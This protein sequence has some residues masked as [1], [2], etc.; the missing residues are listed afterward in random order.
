MPEHVCPLD[1]ERHRDQVEQAAKKVYA[2]EVIKKLPQAY[3][4]ELLE[5]GSTL[6]SGERQLIALARAVLFDAKIIILDEATA[7]IDVETEYLIQKALNDLS[8]DKTIISIAHRL[9]TVKSSKRIIVVHKGK[10]A[11]EG[12]HDE[13]MVKKGIYF[14]LYRLQF[15][16]S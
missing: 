11:E 8:A 10:V 13:L 1:P 3:D 16:N 15:E 9:S 6:S 2:D 12:S 14:D 5:R 4:S 7:N